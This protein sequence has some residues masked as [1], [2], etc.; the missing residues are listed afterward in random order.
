MD[1][2]Y[3]VEIVTLYG[4]IFKHEYDCLTDAEKRYHDTLL[5]NEDVDSVTIFWGDTIIEQ[6][7]F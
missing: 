6:T 4:D 3:I 5:Y 7:Y 1:D 2:N